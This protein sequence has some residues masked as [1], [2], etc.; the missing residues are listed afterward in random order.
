LI[1]FGDSI[2]CREWPSIIAAQVKAAISG[3]LRAAMFC[4]NRISPGGSDLNTSSLKYALE[5]AH[6]IAA[7]LEADETPESEKPGIV[8]ESPEMLKS[9]DSEE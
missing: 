3:D 5:G 7:L 2:V 8:N 1:Y 6:N 4:Q 9:R